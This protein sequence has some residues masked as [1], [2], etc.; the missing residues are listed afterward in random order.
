MRKLK[1]FFTVVGVGAVGLVALLMYAVSASI[2]PAHPE[3]DGTTYLQQQAY[4]QQVID[5]VIQL[6]Q[7]DAATFNKLAGEDSTNVRFLL[8]QNPFISAELLQTLSQDESDFV[9]GGAALNPHLTQEQIRRLSND[10]SHTT[11]IY[12]ARNPHV[13]EA[14]LLRLHEVHGI[15]LVWFAMNPACP[16]V[17]KDKMKAQND[18][19]ALYWLDTSSQSPAS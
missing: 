13:P 9:R 1:I 10:P 17:L 12:V 15:E 5:S 7:L 14:D 18:E 6:K 2:G 16:K 4:P 11:Q 19:E 8:A 3:R